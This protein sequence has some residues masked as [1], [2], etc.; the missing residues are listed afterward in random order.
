[1]ATVHACRYKDGKL[2][3]LN[4][5]VLPYAAEELAVSEEG[6]FDTILLLNFIEHVMDAF[7]IYDIAFRALDTTGRRRRINANSTFTP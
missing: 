2:G 4:T 1:M 6:R 7:R 3:N 5:I